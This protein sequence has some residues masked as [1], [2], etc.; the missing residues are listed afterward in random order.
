VLAASPT[1]P[2]LAVADEDIPNDCIALLCRSIACGCIAMLDAAHTLGAATRCA[3]LRRACDR[4]RRLRRGDPLRPASPRLR[5][6]TWKWETRGQLAQ[7][8]Q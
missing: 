5:S 6:P 3:R 2:P 7:S 8:V 4:R 1:A